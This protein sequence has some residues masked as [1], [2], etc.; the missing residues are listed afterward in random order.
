MKKKIYSEEEVRE[1]LYGDPENQ[2]TDNMDINPEDFG[3]K[4]N[5]GGWKWH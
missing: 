1:M 4:K 3:F 5:K 2:L